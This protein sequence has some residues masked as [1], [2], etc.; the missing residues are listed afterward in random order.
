GGGLGAGGFF[1]IDDETDVVAVALGAARFLAVESCGQCEPCKRDGLAIT[2]QLGRLA[3]S[4]AALDELDR[5]AGR[6]ATVADGARCD[7]AFQQE[8][9]GASALRLFPDSFAGHLDGSA[10][11]TTAER[12]LPIVDIVEG[13]AVLDESHLGKQ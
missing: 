13:T 3:A 1:V 4:D 8:R 12:L 11:P 10:P 9:V 5:L 7:L 2:Q 6:L